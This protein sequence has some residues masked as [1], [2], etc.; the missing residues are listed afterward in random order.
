MCILN[1][2]LHECCPIVVLPFAGPVVTDPNDPFA[3]SDA[4]RLFL[5]LFAKDS[6][7]MALMPTNDLVESFNGLV[8]KQLK[9][10]T[11]QFQCYESKPQQ[12]NAKRKRGRPAKQATLSKKK[13]KTSETAGALHFV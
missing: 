7:V 2:A 6:T 5:G 9:L 10:E 4:V 1:L 13:L 11:K 8:V 3:L 12:V